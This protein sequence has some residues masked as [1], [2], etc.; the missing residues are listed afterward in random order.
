MPNLGGLVFITFQTRSCYS[1][2]TAFSKWLFP[3]LSLFCFSFFGVGFWFWVF[4][5][6]WLDI[7]KYVMLVFTS[8]EMMFVEVAYSYTWHLKHHFKV[9]AIICWWG[10]LGTHAV[11]S[12]RILPLPLG[13]TCLSLWRGCSLETLP[14]HRTNSGC[15]AAPA[16]AL[17]SGLGPEP[18]PR[19][20]ARGWVG[21]WTA[22]LHG[23]V[24]QWAM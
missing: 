13:R 4:F 12:G 1:E 8:L 21:R 24:L 10:W 15:A 6:T 7:L 9:L 19:P 2:K 14:G 16:M 22:W 5:C 17:T 23:L 20:S 3:F 18:G 11:T